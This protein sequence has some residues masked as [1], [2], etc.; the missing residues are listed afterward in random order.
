MPHSV[1]KYTFS[2]IHTLRFSVGSMVD[3]MYA[4]FHVD[5]IVSQW[6][7][8]QYEREGYAPVEV[9]L[10][11]FHKRL[12]DGSFLFSFVDSLDKKPIGDNAEMLSEYKFMKAIIREVANRCDI[13]S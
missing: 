7:K 12:E 3:D 5:G 13:Q 6:V 10:L 9:E 11:V 4:L 1:N 2:N 8:F